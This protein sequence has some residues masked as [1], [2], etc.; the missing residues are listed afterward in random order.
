VLAVAA[1][2]PPAENPMMPTRRGS[3]C[4]CRAFCRTVRSPAAHP[5]AARGI[6]RRATRYSSTTPTIPCWLSHRATPV[7]FGAA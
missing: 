2:C 4:H 7:A 5:T 6:D 3:T 1:R